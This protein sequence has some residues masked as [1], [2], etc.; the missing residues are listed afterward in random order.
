MK[1]SIRSATFA[2]VLVALAPLSTRAADQ[3]ALYNDAENLIHNTDDVKG[4]NALIAKGLNVKK[5]SQNSQG[6]TLLTSAA[7]EG[8]IPMMD[9]LIKAGVNPNAKDDSGMTALRHVAWTGKNQVA[10]AKRLIAAKANVNLADDRQ[11]TP[12][13]Q[14]MYNEPDVAVP[15]GAV[16]L[17]AG[18]DASI[19]NN[20]QN[21]ALTIA[22]DRGLVAIIPT[23]IK[24]H[25]DVDFRGHDGTSLAIASE[26]GNAAVAK[27]LLD[28]HA[29][30]DLADK[31]N[32]TPLMKAAQ[33]DKVDVIVLLLQHCA[34]TDLVD[35]FFKWDALKFAQSDAA[36]SAIQT[37]PGANCKKGS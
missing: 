8:K 3:E 5:P 36:K 35:S 12:L 24:N 22:A 34:R 16:L 6:R 25:A 4:L 33:R 11:W 29:N 27:A 10:A 2:L 15:L 19:V 1:R 9:V 30:P 28:A 20:E 14:A 13:I 21:T 23:L 26:K 18:A 17:G 7:T 31:K 37:G 32:M